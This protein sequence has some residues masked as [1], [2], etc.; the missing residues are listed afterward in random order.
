MQ[1]RKTKWIAGGAL[2]IVL[3]AGALAWQDSA[4]GAGSATSNAAPAPATIATIDVFRCLQAYMLRPEMVA[5]RDAQNTE[6]QATEAEIRTRIENNQ[7]RLRGLAQG[8]PQFAL[9]RSAIEADSQA[10]NAFRQQATLNAQALAVAQSTE[11]FIEVQEQ[12]SALAGELGYSHLIS[13]KLDASDLMGES[14]PTSQSTAQMI[15]ELLARPVLLA[16]AGDDITERV[17]EAM[18]ILQYE[19]ELD[20]AASD[21]DALPEPTP[22]PAPAPA[23]APGGGG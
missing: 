20:A 1:L 17:L 4:G 12:A 23:P 18:D 10:Y 21:P 13:G 7:Q 2:A 9:T 19:A 22:A 15:Q 11:A 16:P 3:G 6:F 8:D 14:G 5:A